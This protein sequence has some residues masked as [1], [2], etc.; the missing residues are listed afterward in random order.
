MFVETLVM[1]DSFEEQVMRRGTELS[2]R[3][4]L[5]VRLMNEVM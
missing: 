4:G 3:G 2:R 1:K 5:P